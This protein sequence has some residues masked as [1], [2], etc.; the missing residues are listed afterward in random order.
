MSMF[1]RFTHEARAA[2][3]RAQEEAR[4]L[5][6]SW[7]GCEHLLLAVLAQP[8]N[9]ATTVLQ[10]FGVT[11]ER[12]RAAIE[13]LIGSGGRLSDAEA[14]RTLGIDLDEVRRRVEANFGPGALDQPPRRRRSRLPLP[15]RRQPDCEPQPLTGHIA[16]TP[17]AKQAME[18][19][20][21]EALALKD[22]HIGPEHILLG[23]LR[24]KTNL[25]VELLRRLNVAP[26]A[27]RAQL[28]T[29]LGKAA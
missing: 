5:G 6:H 3:V 13:D 23:I 22:R 2:V 16:F 11:A 14:L 19:A 21:R 28:L 9:P 26:D 24:V 17:R 4:A 8:D 15:W 12:F 20:L 10:R 27:V 7:I 29:E 25:A 18:L 1:E